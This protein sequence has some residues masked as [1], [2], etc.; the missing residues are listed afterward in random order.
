MYF[1]IKLTAIAAAY[2]IAVVIAISA[3]FVFYGV[4]FQYYDLTVFL[5]GIG[6]ILVPQ[7]LFFLGAGI[8]A[9][10]LQHNLSFL[11]LALI[12]LAG[13]YQFSPNYYLDV[14]GNS[15][16]GIPRNAVP[17]KG[18]IA[19]QVPADYIIARI[20]LGVI[21]AVLIYAGC[22]RYKSK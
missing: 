1:F 15:I 17:L 4:V 20:I 19:Y 11:L 8:W 22:K 6:L 14:L 16:L 18:V 5:S 9:C 12:F 3:C 2:L 7:L 10:R 21:G 13:I